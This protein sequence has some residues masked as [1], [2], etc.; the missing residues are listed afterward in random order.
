M[1]RKIEYVAKC[2]SRG[3]HKHYETFII[4]QIY[5]RLNN[6]NIEIATQQYAKDKEGRVR[7]I[8][9]YFPQFFVAVEIDEPYHDSLEQK[10]RDKLREIDIKEAV[11]ES[12][13]GDRDKEIDFVRISL[14]E[15]PDL[16]SLYEKIDSVVKLIQNKIKECTEPVVWNIDDKSKIDEIKRRGYLRRG[17]SFRIMADIIR[18]FGINQKSDSYRRCSYKFKN[19]NLQIWSPTLSVEGSDR[20][21]WVN[22]ITDN[23]EIIYESNKDD[24]ERVMSNS[25]YHQE[26][27]TTRIVFLKYKDALGNQRRR[28]LGVYHI[29]GFNEDKKGEIW[30][31]TSKTINLNSIKEK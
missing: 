6:P 20:D 2:L 17:D 13:I 29:D 10:G 1:D 22:T 24:V 21:G 25:R 7:Y 14:S 11:L 4:N 16:S 30:K 9:L 18:I 26:H 3:N 12:A 31:L 28:F 8:D 15:S 27:D 23:L 19:S 5:A